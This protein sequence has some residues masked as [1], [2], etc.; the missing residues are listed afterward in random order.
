MSSQKTKDKS[1]GK[2]SGERRAGAVAVVEQPTHR[3]LDLLRL[4]PWP[5]VAGE[6]ELRIEE[7][8]DGDTFVVRAEV[9]GIDP[10]EVVDIRVADHTLHL[11]V[12][13]RESSR[14]EDTHGFRS[15]FRYGSL[16]RAVP[17]A[18]GATERDVTAT[19]KDGILEVRMPVD[20]QKESVQ[21][22]PVAR[23]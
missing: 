2:G 3:L 18:A 4:P 10:D 9:P 8:R 23:G 20:T 7:L 11:R 5:T 17:L 15:E 19:Y 12:E 14:T 22:I 13:R 21:R 6:H 1:K 16:Y